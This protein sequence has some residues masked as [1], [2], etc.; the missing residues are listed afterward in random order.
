MLRPELRRLERP[1]LPRQMPSLKERR[2]LGFGLDKADQ[3]RFGCLCLN[4]IG[5]EQAPYATDKRRAIQTKQN[6][7]APK[8]IPDFAL[9]LKPNQWVRN[10]T[11][12]LN[13]DIH[14]LIWFTYSIQHSENKIPSILRHILL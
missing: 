1:K 13:K 10:L 5:V 11:I 8:K 12:C 14:C 3:K 9:K 7:V 2:I 6:I 4:L